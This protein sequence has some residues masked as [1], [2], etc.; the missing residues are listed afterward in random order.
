MAEKT[1]KAIT[2]EK[3]ISIVGGI[4]KFQYFLNTLLI[5]MTIPVTFQVFIVCFSTVSPTWI[6]AANSTSCIYN[7]T[8]KAEDTSRCRLP[9]NEWTYTEAKTYSLVTQFDLVCEKEWFIELISSSFFICWAIGSIVIGW[10]A[11]NYGRKVVLMPCYVIIITTG[12][13]S[14]FLPNL[15]LFLVSRII[16][17][18]AY[19]GTYVQM[20][21]LLSETVCSKHR[22]VMGL[23]FWI[24]IPVS[25]CMI[26]LFAYLSPNW[27]ILSIVSTAPFICVVL[28]YK[29]IPESLVWLQMQGR[30]EL[31]L[32]NLKRI[33][34]W[35][36]RPLPDNVFILPPTEQG[37]HKSNPLDLFGT[38]KLALHSL[39][40]F[41]SWV[42]VGM[43]YYGL[44]LEANNLG[45]SLYRDYELLS[46]VDVPAIMLAMIIPELVGRKKAVAI[47]MFFGSIACLLISVFS[48]EGHMKI[49]R[50]VLGLVGKLLV[51]FSFYA[52]YTWSLELFPIHLRSE[53]M[54]LLQLASKVGGGAAPWIA[55]GLLSVSQGTPY[56]VMG[57]AGMIAALAELRLPETSAKCSAKVADEKER[58]IDMNKY[59]TSSS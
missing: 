59:S 21:V 24:G 46:I 44:S 29:F 47:P 4:G 15:Y 56:L 1:K 40:Q 7:D 53:G 8:R 58:K 30:T 25:Y 52:M 57:G 54:G 28:F 43:V 12:F 6:C 42:V 50:V 3:A 34:V 38:R 48:P 51:S 16:I 5:C 17:G 41:Y 32:D 36:K 37:E 39:I 33:G 35:N 18:I 45:G 11:D 19:S 26:G 10:I 20:F 27:K 31:I 14:S 55:K 9:R 13:I 22:P 23:C 49:A 2:I